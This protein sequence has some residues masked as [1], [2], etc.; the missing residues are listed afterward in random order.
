MNE[1]FQLLTFLLPGRVSIIDLNQHFSISLITEA[2]HNG[3]LEVSSSGVC[4]LTDSGIQRRLQLL[5]Q[6]ASEERLH[7]QEVAQ[8]SKRQSHTKREHLFQLLLVFIGWVLGL[9]TASF[10]HFLDRLF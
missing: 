5:D 9:L 1:E 2:K 8:E 4:R 10:T 6:L 7:D 3:F